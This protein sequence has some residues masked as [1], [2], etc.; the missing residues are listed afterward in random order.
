MAI[1]LTYYAQ[2]YR[3]DIKPYESAIICQII[4]LTQ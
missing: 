4:T 1:Y 3:L 2:Q